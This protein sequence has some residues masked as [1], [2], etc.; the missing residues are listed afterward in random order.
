MWEF[1]QNDP[2][3]DSGSKMVRLGYAKRLRLNQNF[4]GIVLS[5]D[6]HLILSPADAPLIE[7]YGINSN[8][9]Y[10]TSKH[11]EGI[12]KNGISNWHR[13]SFGICKNY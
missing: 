12:K 11:I 2:K 9:G 1:G 6:A 7:K 5:S 13:K 4:S 3:R 10:G 8:K